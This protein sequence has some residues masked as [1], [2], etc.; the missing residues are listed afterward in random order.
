METLPLPMVDRANGVMIVDAD[1]REYLDGC[2]GTICVNIGHGV[3]EVLDAIAKQSRLVTFAHRSQFRNQP[4]EDLSALILGIA[5]PGYKEVVYT[6]SGSEAIEAALRLAMHHHAGTGRDIVVSQ[7]PSYH[8]MTAGALSVSG[9]PP[10]RCNL[11]VLLGG[12]AR[13]EQVSSSRDAEILPSAAGWLE[14]LERLD[15]T[16]IAAVVLE[17]VVGAAG[18]AAEVDVQTLTRLREFCD[19]VGAL[20]IADEVMT[21]FGRT[22]EWFGVTLSRITPDLMVTGKGLSGGYLPIGACLVGERVLSGVSAAEVSMGHTMS[23]NPLAAAAALAVLAYT[24]DHQLVARAR[25][26]G[27]YVRQ[28]LDLMTASLPFLQQPRGRGLLLGVGIEQDPAEFATAPLNRRIVQAALRNG[29]LV[30][31]AGVDARTQSVMVCPP[32]TIRDSEVEMLVERLTRAM[33]Q[34]FAVERV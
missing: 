2:S 14:V 20:L 6:N 27:A 9:H 4:I 1:G 32:L 29:L 18:G 8:G 3:P 30:Y 10:R 12:A 25:E 7:R 26:V 15:P 22:G 31:P 11:E 19:N 17:P 33:S 13:L 34:T 21:G 28:E 5:G 16:R 24:T 23:G